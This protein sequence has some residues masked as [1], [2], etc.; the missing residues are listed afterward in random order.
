MGAKELMHRSVAFRALALALPLLL[1]TCGKR[2]PPDSE[3][4]ATSM[5]TSSMQVPS[6]DV[7]VHSA[8]PL[9]ARSPVRLLLSVVESNG[10]TPTLDPTYN[11]SLHVILVSRDLRWYRHIHSD[12]QPASDVPIDVT[13]S[14]DGE[15]VLFAYFRPAGAEVQSDRVPLTVGA[16]RRS[17]PLTLRPTPLGREARGYRIEMTESPTPLRA[18]VWESLT[19]RMLHGGTTVPN[20]GP[21][22]SFGHLAIVREGANDFVFAHSTVEEAGGIRRGMHVPAHPALPDEPEHAVQPVGP[23]VTFHARFPR[24]GRYKLW[25]EFTPGGDDVMADFVVEVKE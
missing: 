25:A 6:F 22:G 21:E 9:Y 10:A 13:F 14:S 7:R 1:L 16:A 5:P 12:M 19:F 4:P 24:P 20:L 23:E 2:E 15:Y 3:A 17:E 11:A 18:N 8:K